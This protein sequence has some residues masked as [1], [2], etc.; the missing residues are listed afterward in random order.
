MFT[1]VDHI[2]HR[3]NPFG[4][5]FW[6]VILEDENGDNFFDHFSTE[7][8]DSINLSDSVTRA[9][10]IELSHIELYFEVYLSG[11]SKM[12]ISHYRKIESIKCR[13]ERES[14]INYILGQ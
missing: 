13:L 8:Y 12:E 7:D 9:V 5:I 1:L 4:L 3:D 10:P 11:D 2:S 6:Y 14:K